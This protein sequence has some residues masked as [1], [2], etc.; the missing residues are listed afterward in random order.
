[1]EHFLDD[2]AATKEIA[3]VL[4]PGGHYVAL[5]HVALTSGQRFAQKVREYVFPRPRP[6]RL[7]RWL[8]SKMVKP[9]Y[10]PIQLHYTARSAQSRLEEGG[11][12]I[13]RVIS[14]HTVPKPPL[15]GPHVFVYVAH[16]AG[17][18]AP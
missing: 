12:T 9:V 1:M 16:T 8:A 13:D 18:A 11:F 10:Q 4:R 17:A 6:I 3:R 15:V 7:A 5:I 14:V 2:V